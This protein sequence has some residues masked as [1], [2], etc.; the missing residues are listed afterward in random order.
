MLLDPIL[1]SQGLCLLYAK[2]GVGK[3]HVA[4]HIAYAVATGGTFLRWE[5]TRPY[6]V[7][8]IDGEMPAKSMQERLKMIALKAEKKLPAP[9]YLQLITPDLQGS[10]LPNLGTLEGQAII[11]Q[12]SV[13]V[14]LIIVDNLSTLV[15]N[16][17]ENEAESWLP[18]QTW[19]LKK[20]REGKSLLF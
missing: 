11:D 4:L 9:D 16:G 7:L 1:P 19:A 3:T 13:E 17:I 2:R 10:A 20:R 6:K 5:A 15:R 12:L 18:I 8:Y 14:D